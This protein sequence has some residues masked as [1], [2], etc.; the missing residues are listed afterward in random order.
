MIPIMSTSVHI[1]GEAII[2]ALSLLYVVSRDNPDYKTRLK[3]VIKAVWWTRARH[4][5][6]DA[7]YQRWHST[8]AQVPALL[9]CVLAMPCCQVAWDG[10]LWQCSAP[11]VF[12]GYISF[13]SS[14]RGKGMPIYP[15]ES[16]GH[17]YSTT[18]CF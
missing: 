7:G 4:R 11:P 3:A 14:G 2:P 15:F 6:T 1:L 5:S 10:A 18:N 13:R 17:P 8:S 9:L 12:W 16:A